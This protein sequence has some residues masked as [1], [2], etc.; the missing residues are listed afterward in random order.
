MKIFTF[1]LNPAVDY[2]ADI[3]NIVLNA[4]NKNIGENYKAGGKGINV[5]VVLKNLGCDST[6]LGLCGGFTGDYILDSINKLCIKND[7][8]KTEGTTRINIKLRDKYITEINGR[9]PVISEDEIN[10]LKSKLKTIDPEDIIILSG[11]LPMGVSKSIYREIA[12]ISKCRF[13]LDTTGDAFK[14]GLKAK[15][16]VVKPNISELSDYFNVEINDYSTAVF[17]GKKLIDT[18]AENVIVSM[19]ADGSV[20]ID[21]NK[22]H[23]IE[24]GVNG[25]VVNT[26]GAGDSMVAGFVYGV[27]KGFEVTKA[28]K[29]AHAC[30]T[31]C[32]FT[33]NL[34][35][36]KDIEKYFGEKL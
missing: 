13:V 10:K 16:F 15:P 2:V 26:V 22:N 11:S 3:N 19:G 32:A 21:K 9:G 8:V 20:L 1:T 31:A 12:E 17:Y 36:K 29:L 7:F 24:T 35:D 23:Y 25:N 4:T 27:T 14:E 30:G 34:P 33:E 5:S 28:F 18:G 6:A